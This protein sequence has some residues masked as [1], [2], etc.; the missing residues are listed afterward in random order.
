MSVLSD[1][2]KERRAANG[3]TLLQVADHLGVKEATAQRYESGEIKNVK[4]EIVTQLADLFHCNPAYLMGWTDSPS[5]IED[6]IPAPLS[7]PEKFLITVY[8]SISRD[9]QQY[10]IQQATIASEIYKNQDV[11]SALENNAV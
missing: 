4:H 9:G 3:L 7:D 10:L 2:I 8:N 5:I 6:S 1:R 11:I